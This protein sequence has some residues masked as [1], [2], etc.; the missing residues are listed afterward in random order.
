M[1]YQ[2]SGQYQHQNLERLIGDALRLSSVPGAGGSSGTM[3]E[4]FA[5]P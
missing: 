4:F 3:G 1:A 5:Q 2:G